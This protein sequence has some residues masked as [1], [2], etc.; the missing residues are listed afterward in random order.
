MLEAREKDL[1]AQVIALQNSGN[2]T[3]RVAP[4]VSKAP[5]DEVAVQARLQPVQSMNIVTF[6]VDPAMG[7]VRRQVTRDTIQVFPQ[8]WRLSTQY[9]AIRPPSSAPPTSPVASAAAAASSVPSDIVVKL[10]RGTTG[11]AMSR[12]IAY[13]HA[14]SQAWHA[15]V[16]QHKKRSAPPS[17]VNNSTLKPF[18]FGDMALIELQTTTAGGSSS[19]QQVEGDFSMDVL[20]MASRDI[21]GGAGVRMPITAAAFSHYSLQ[22]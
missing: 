13:G 11:V 19:P 9:I 12:R 7:N 17:S 21:D 18:R 20:S 10:D 15:F 5:Q 14:F 2:E 16:E 8:P 1:R 22:V 6:V 3:K 4:K